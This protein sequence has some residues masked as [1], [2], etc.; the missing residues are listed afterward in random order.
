MQV[1][2]TG[3]DM[4]NRV[5][6]YP[7]NHE[8]ILLNGWRALTGIQHGVLKSFN[9]LLQIGFLPFIRTLLPCLAQLAVQSA[10]VFHMC[11]VED[12]GLDANRPKRPGLCA[13]GSNLT[14]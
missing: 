2:K 3:T 6:Q 7:R 14:V 1:L 4:M 10:Q 12:P 5:A 8:E 9:L 11:Y 13:P